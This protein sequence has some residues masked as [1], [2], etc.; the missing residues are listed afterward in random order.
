[1]IDAEGPA[2]VGFDDR[3]RT[4]RMWIAIAVGS[5]ACWLWPGAE[6]VAFFMLPIAIAVLLGMRFV[7]PMAPTAVAEGAI[8]VDARGIRVRASG[9]DL[10]VERDEVE[11]GWIE[12]HPTPA[13]VLRTRRGIVCA[14]VATMERAHTILEACGATA[15]EMV[16]RFRIA[17][18][19]A[20]IP[21]ASMAAGAFALAATVVVIVGA[22]KIAWVLAGTRLFD[23]P[24]TMVDIVWTLLGLM[25]LF[26]VGVATR[27]RLVEIGRDSIVIHSLFT[28]RIPISALTSMKRLRTGLLLGTADAEIRLDVAS[29]HVDIE[30]LANYELF[31]LRETLFARIGASCSLEAIALPPERL[32]VLERAER[33]LPEYRDALSSLV[34]QESYRAQTFTPAELVAVVGARDAAPRL[35]IAAAWALSAAGDPIAIERARAASRALVDEDVR[36]ATEQA[37]DGDERAL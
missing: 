2:A 19:A 35:R 11:D 29:W 4:R 13:A 8:E 18:V 7:A 10:R 14:R 22:M 9:L 34:R 27:P 33:S 17:P 3:R 31:R 24:L 30:R 32:C 36:I 1:V 6:I 20:R 5:A 23:K 16:S 25:V 28:Q 12:P 37:L 15:G 26:L 21:L